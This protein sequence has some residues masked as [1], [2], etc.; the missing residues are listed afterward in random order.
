MSENGKLFESILSQAKAR[1]TGEQLSCYD[2][3]YGYVKVYSLKEPVRNSLFDT[4]EDQK[5]LQRIDRTGPERFRYIFCH[6]NVQ[7]VL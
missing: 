1:S 2:L 4:P 3:L 5:E 6:R 7:Y